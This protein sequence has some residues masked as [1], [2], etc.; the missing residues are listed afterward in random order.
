MTKL[1]TVFDT[2]DTEH[3][4]VA[5]DDAVGDLLPALRIRNGILVTDVALSAGA[6]QGLFLPGDV[7]HAVNGQSPSSVEELENALMRIMRGESVV[8]QI[9]RTGRLSFVVAELF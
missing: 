6:P 2:Y 4:A 8:L 1:L 9:E 5:I 7:I 3:Q